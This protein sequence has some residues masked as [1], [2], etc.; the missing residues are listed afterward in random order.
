M[1]PAK[2]IYKHIIVFSLISLLNT[3][4]LQAQSVFL[5]KVVDSASNEPLEFVTVKY[6]TESWKDTIVF[7][8][9]KNGQFIIRQAH[10]DSLFLLVL[11]HLGYKTST[12]KLKDGQTLSSSSGCHVWITY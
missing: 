8:S 2:Y 10:Q 3:P 1:M 7:L 5:G 6:V 12:L 11:S 9:D 4:G